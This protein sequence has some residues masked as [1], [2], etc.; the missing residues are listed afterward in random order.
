MNVVTPKES[1]PPS[2]RLSYQY[3]LLEIYGH[4]HHRGYA[5][6][7][8]TRRAKTI[9]LLSEALPAGASVLDLAAAQGNFSLTLAEMGYQVTWNDLREELVDYVRMKHEHGVIAYA[10][11][12]AFEAQFPALFDAV[13]ATEVLEHVA[14]PEKFLARVANLT[15]PGGVIVVTTPNGGYFR[16]S[17]PGLSDIPDR[18]EIE[19]RQFLPDADGHLFL[20]HAEELITVAKDAGLEVEKLILFTNPLTAGHIKL[21]ALLRVLPRRAVFAFEACTEASPQFLARR[22]STQLAA[23]LR[24]P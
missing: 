8:A 16:N 10:P 13:V 21:E 18:T 15:R 12:N 20:M 11:G 9:N 22:I 4:L 23:R 24:V 6:A 14:Y 1:W 5:Y 2:W 19:S 3:D 17:L 7:Y